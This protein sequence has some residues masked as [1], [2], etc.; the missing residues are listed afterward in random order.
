MSAYKLPVLSIVSESYWYLAQNSRRFLKLASVP[1]LIYCTFYAFVGGN[2]PHAQDSE[3]L[4]TIPILMYGLSIY[5]VMC[6]VPAMIIWHR[7]VVGNDKHTDNNEFRWFVRKGEWGFAI[8]VFVLS[9]L[10]GVLL[11]VVSAVMLLGVNPILNVGSE[12]S[13]SFI[14]VLIKHA[15][16]AV[17]LFPVSGFLLVLPS[18][19]LHDRISYRDAKKV[20]AG[21]LTRLWLIN[22]MTLAPLAVMSLLLDM[23]EQFTGELSIAN[24][25]DVYLVLKVLIATPFV[26]V[27]V[28]TLSISFKSLKEAVPI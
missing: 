23:S 28:G 6:A 27:F 15:G 12:D 20:W 10:Y 1:F 18:I 22:L 11:H 13:P 17:A 2:G 21:N 26:A 25:I 8:E 5:V 4:Y 14:G 3:F 9:L 19:A 16:Y 7:R 24:A